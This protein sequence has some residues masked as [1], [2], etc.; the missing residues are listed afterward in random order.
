MLVLGLLAACQSDSS[1]P[2]PEQACLDTA[3][4]SGDLC[5]RCSLG[6]YEAC[7]QAIL[8]SVDG[9]GVNG[10]CF[11]YFET[12]DCAATMAPGFEVDASWQRHLQHN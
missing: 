10:A 9:D 1:G 4:R 2:S 12:V 7:R 6:T 3:D 5:T 8:D 11:A